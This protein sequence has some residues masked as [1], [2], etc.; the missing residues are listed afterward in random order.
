MPNNLIATLKAEPW[1]QTILFNNYRVLV[2]QA[3]LTMFFTG[4]NRIIRPKNIGGL[5]PLIRNIGGGGFACWFG[6][7]AIKQWSINDDRRYL[8]K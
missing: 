8:K 6:M 5:S 1:P 4:A 3:L 2:Q 7:K